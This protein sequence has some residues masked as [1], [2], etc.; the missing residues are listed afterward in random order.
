[1][2]APRK[3]A[4]MP[5]LANELRTSSSC[6]LR[7]FGEYCQEYQLSDRETRDGLAKAAAAFPEVEEE[8]QKSAGVLS[9]LGK[10]AP[11]LLGG[12]AKAAPLADDA[13][14]VGGR[15]LGPVAAAPAD[16]RHHHTAQSVTVRHVRLGW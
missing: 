8:L 3:E 13:A 2:T 4:N 14:R 9:M 6:F 12:A 11:K 7:G 15:V 16:G 10:L 1:M 5:T